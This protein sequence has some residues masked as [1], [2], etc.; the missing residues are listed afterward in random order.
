MNNHLENTSHLKI[1]IGLLVVIAAVSIAFTVGSTT[2]GTTLVKLQ[3]EIE[4]SRESVRE[5]S[6][7]V[8]EK[9]SL[10]A[11]SYRIPNLEMKA[12]KRVFATLPESIALS[13]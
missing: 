8:S 5:L 7:L 10:T 2:S 6:E 11:V 13:R 3:N 4:V 12:M 1:H 9:G